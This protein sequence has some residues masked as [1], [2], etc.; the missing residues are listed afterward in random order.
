MKQATLEGIRELVGISVFK[1]FL[2]YVDV[3]SSQ[4]KILSGKNEMTAKL[5]RH[6]YRVF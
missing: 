4:Q 2:K 5:K 1:L 6:V 3:K